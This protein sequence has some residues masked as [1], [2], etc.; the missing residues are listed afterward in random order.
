MNV[1]LSILVSASGISL[2][3]QSRPTALPWNITPSTSK[4]VR[5]QHCRETRTR[6]YPAHDRE[7]KIVLIGP[8]IKGLAIQSSQL[9]DLGIRRSYPCGR[10]RGLSVSSRRLDCRLRLAGHEISG[11]HRFLCPEVVDGLLWCL[12]HCA[13][14]GQD[15]Q[16]DES[17]GCARSAHVEKLIDSAGWDCRC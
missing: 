16:K 11:V 10:R 15:R 12:W 8:G 13:Y 14:Q 4:E 1:A 17:K 5:Y 7:H 6:Q 3:S 2:D 9:V